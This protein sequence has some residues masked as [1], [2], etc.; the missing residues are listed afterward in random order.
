MYP[1]SSKGLNRE[2]DEAVYFF[3]PT[4]APLDNFSAHTVRVWGKTFP[5]AE[6]AFQWKKFSSSHDDVAEKILLAES[7][8]AVKRISDQYKSA[9]PFSWID[10]RTVVMEQILRSKAEQHED[11]R[12]ALKRTGIRTIIENS[13]VDNFWGIGPDKKGENAVGKIWMKIRD[14]ILSNRHINL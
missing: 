1:A 6:H 12:D 8:H 3:T 2:T 14:E 13:P 11:V 9:V 4:F 5:T 10:E 7:P